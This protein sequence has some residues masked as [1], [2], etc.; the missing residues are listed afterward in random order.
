MVADVH[1]IHHPTAIPAAVWEFRRRNPNYFKSQLNWERMVSSMA[2]QQLGWV[3]ADDIDAD[4]AYT[5]LIQRGHWTV[6]NLTLAFKTLMRAGVLE[7]DPDSP[8]PLNERDQTR[9][10]AA[11]GCRRCGRR[12]GSIYPVAFAPTSLG[13]VDV[14]NVVAGG[15]RWRCRSPI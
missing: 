7:V 11:S 15:A 13:N 6:D 14:V 9:C 5:E 10:C 2:R 1:F 12:S 3:D 4:D 8:R